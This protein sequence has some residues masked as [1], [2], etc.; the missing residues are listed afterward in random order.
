[1]SLSLSQVGYLHKLVTA[2]PVASEPVTKTLI[3]LGLA[4]RAKDPKWALPTRDGIITYC[5]LNHESLI[6]WERR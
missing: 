6:S 2:Y 4:T 1:M 3:E 5:R